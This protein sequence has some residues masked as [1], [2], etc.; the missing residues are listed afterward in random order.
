MKKR[1]ALRG[2]AASV[3]IP[4]QIRH[5]RPAGWAKRSVP[6]NTE[7]GT[8]NRW[9]RPDRCWCDAQE[10][11]PLPILRHAPT[12]FA[13]I[14]SPQT[15]RPVGWAKRS[16]PINTESGTGNRWARPDHCWCD[17]QESW[18]LPILR[19]APT[20]F[21]TIQ[22]PQTRRPVGWAKRSVPINT[23]SGTG[24]RWARPD[25][26]WCDAQESWPLP[27][28]RHAPTQF[29]TIR[30]PQTRR[31]V[32][33]AK[34]SVPINTESGTG[35]RWAR[36]DRCWCDAQESWPL[37]ILRHAPTQFA[38]IRA[39]QTR[40]PVGWAKHSVPINTESGT[41]NRWARPDRCWCDA[42][43]SWPLPILRYAPTQF[44]TIQSP[45]TRR[46]VGWA[47]RSVP[48]GL[49]RPALRR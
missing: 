5:Q 35:N 41:G 22:S 49:T 26:C 30:A 11:W 1:R 21:A 9:A 24:I 39:P 38:T 4:D 45:Q 23:E 7:S 37:P 34:H 42:Q 32:G 40:R 15:R 33:W 12:Q 43:E 46:P 13:T 17:A 18:P 3:L 29:A 48:I 20:Q 47:K 2:S 36:P 8:G 16:V 19:H 31:P 28:L 25:H 10:S 44:A 27:I 6:I 14:Q